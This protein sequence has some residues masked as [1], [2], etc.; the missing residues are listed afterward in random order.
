MYR[1]GVIR[2][3]HGPGLGRVIKREDVRGM[4]GVETRSLM[5]DLRDGPQHHTTCRVYNRPWTVEWSR[6]STTLGSS[7]TWGRT[8]DAG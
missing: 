3:G 5:R 6:P 1:G 4:V 8:W 2:Q 7:T